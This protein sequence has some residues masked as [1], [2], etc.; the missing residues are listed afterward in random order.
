MLLWTTAA[1]C[2]VAAVMLTC[3]AASAVYT[4]VVVL[5]GGKRCT[6]GTNDEVWHV[7]VVVKVLSQ[8]AGIMQLAH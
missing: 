8:T 4:S 2:N 5:R 7:P 3:G 1:R 6:K